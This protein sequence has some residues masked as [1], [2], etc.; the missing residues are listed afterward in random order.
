MENYFITGATGLVGAA[1]TEHLVAKGENVTA[2]VRDVEKARKMFSHL[3]RVSI[4]YGSLENGITYEGDIDYIVHAA[5]PTDSNFFIEHPVETIDSIVLGT[6]SVLEF[7]KSKKAKSVVNLSSME[8]YGV[9]TDEQELTEDQQ[10]YIDPL[11]VRSNYP[12]AKRLTETMCVSYASEYNV[13]VKIARLAQVLGKK[14][15][16][17]DNRVIAQFIRAAKEG[18]DIELATDGKTKQT[19][20]GID[21]TI[22]GILTILHKGE[23]GQAYNIANDE[24][25]CSIRELAETVTRSIASD[26][27]KV[28]TNAKLNEGK[29]PPNRTLRINSD[30]LIALGW[31]PESS[32]EESLSAL[33]NN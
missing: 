6:R 3:T 12:M 7:A 8:V 31:R 10:F 5:A 9:S 25:Y 27:I 23:D 33:S 21:D 4:A 24:T 20:V 16:P 26:N 11:Q 15:L 2:Y 29:Y 18:S 22:A 14:L 19:Y 28:V 1:L 13:P 30:K 17:D 32:L